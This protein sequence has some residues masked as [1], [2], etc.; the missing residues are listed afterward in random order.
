MKGKETLTVKI[1]QL[2]L[3]PVLLYHQRKDVNCSAVG[4]F[5]HIKFKVI[6][7]CHKKT[8]PEL[9]LSKFNSSVV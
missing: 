3:L 6:V 4:H 7:Y 1:L 2:V 9:M 5:H 8:V